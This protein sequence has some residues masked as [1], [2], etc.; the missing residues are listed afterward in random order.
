MAQLEGTTVQLLEA[1]RLAEFADVVHGRLALLL[2]DNAAEISL[3]RTAA[4]TMEWARLY[5]NAADQLRDVDPAQDGLEELLAEIGA[6]TVSRTLANRV[7][8]DYEALVDFVASRTP[9]SL[10]PEHAECLKIIH[11]YRNAAYHRDAVRADVLGP[12]VEI[13]FYLCCHLLKA[14]RQ[15]VH[16]LAPAPPTVLKFLGDSSAETGFPMNAYSA[17]GLAGRVADM[18]L[19]DLR[20]NHDEI[21]TALS[22]HLV[23]RLNQL[24]N[25]LDVIGTSGVPTPLP[26]TLRL[27]QQAPKTPE[28][29]AAPLAPDFWTRELAV[30]EATLA[31]WKSTAHELGKLS[32]ARE[33]L[34]AFAAVERPMED[35]E[36]P[37]SRWIED[38]DREEQARIEWLRGK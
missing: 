3:R 13:L 30:T 6:H 23:G 31:D 8:R 17:V 7:D 2:L 24:K 28:E 9:D 22:D 15:I 14:E 19:M 29:F 27:V 33:A 21:A 5:N 35:L 20:L 11:R 26:I 37:V 32:D 4:S 36:K 18:L 12:A 38:I 34:R 16:Q 25:D 1:R 10:P